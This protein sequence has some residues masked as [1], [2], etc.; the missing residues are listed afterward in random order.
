M[1]TNRDFLVRVLESPAFA[2]GAIGIHH[3]ERDDAQALRADLLDGAARRAAVA[4]AALAGQV[5]PAARRRPC[6]ARCPAGGATNPAVDQ[7]ARFA[8]R[9]DELVVA[10]RFGRGGLEHPPSTASRWR[11]TCAWR[12]PTPGR[13]CS[14]STGC[15]RAGRCAPGPDGAVHAGAGRRVLAARARA[16]PDPA[17]QAAPG[18]LLAPMPGNVVRVDVAVGDAVRA[19][20]PLLALEAMKMEHEIVAPADGRVAELPVAVGMQVDAGTLLAAIEEAA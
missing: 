2:A 6:S 17:A 11:A 14:S 15:G 16:P 9:D 1:R 12:A 4:A 13:S 5:P 18:S 3:L 7:E 10:Y 8:D 20:Q 19:G